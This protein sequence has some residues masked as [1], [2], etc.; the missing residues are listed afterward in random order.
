MMPEGQASRALR[1]Y[2]AVEF[3][4]K[5]EFDRVLVDRPLVDATLVEWEG[6]WW[7]FASDHVRAHVLLGCLCPCACWCWGGC[8][9][10]AG[11]L[12]EL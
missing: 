10:N 5:W 8:Y 1:L 12:G 7:L 3:P 6:R 11:Q 4:L 9:C 2:R